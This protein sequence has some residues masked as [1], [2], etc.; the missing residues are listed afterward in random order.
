MKSSPSA[1]E[2]EGFLFTIREICDERRNGLGFFFFFWFIFRPRLTHNLNTR[3]GLS[4][5][6]TPL[7]DAAAEHVRRLYATPALSRYIYHN[8][9]HTESVVAAVDEIC[10][11]LNVAPGDREMLMLAAWFHDVGHVEGSEGHEKRSAKMAEEF[12]LRHRYDRKRIDGVISA[13]AATK[14]PQSPSNKLDEILCDA[15]L[16]YVGSP[17]AIGMTELLR[18]EWEMLNGR[19]YTEKEWVMINVEFFST[20]QFHTSFG[21]N[22]FEHN[23]L[24][25]LRYFEEKLSELP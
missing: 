24:R 2:P 12:L 1:R 21:K 15:D 9:K 13:I 23:R 4:L 14:M 18:R 16:S 6:H 8:L 20:H 5:V 3:Q 17:D 25:T 22:H 10:S 19:K 7:L 11:A